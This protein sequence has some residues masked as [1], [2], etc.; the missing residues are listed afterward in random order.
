VELEVIL[1]DACMNRDFEDALRLESSAWKGERGTAIKSRE[2]ST[3]FIATSFSSR[4]ATPGFD[5][6]F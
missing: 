2:D 4:C 6:I 1:S 5:C 3:T